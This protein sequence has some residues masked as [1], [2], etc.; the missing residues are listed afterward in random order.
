VRNPL[1]VES[2]DLNLVESVTCSD[3]DLRF[4]RNSTLDLKNGQL[5]IEISTGPDDRNERG[6]SQ[7]AIAARMSLEGG[8]NRFGKR[9]VGSPAAKTRNSKQG[10]F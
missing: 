8:C 5:K 4:Q 3:L 10:P 1:L 6:E 9:P 2:P 7:I